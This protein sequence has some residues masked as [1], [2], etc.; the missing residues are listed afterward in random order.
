[1]G[2]LER[3]LEIRLA[4]DGDPGAIAESRFDLAQTLWVL[5]GPARRARAVEL[6]R[7][8]KNGFDLASA[9]GYRDKVDAWLETRPRP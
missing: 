9:P 3:S 2:P 8:A 4:T 7:A 1:M 6:A 5:G